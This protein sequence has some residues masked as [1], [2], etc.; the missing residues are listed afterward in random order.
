MWQFVGLLG[1]LGGRFGAIMYK[2]LPPLEEFKK[3]FEYNPDTGDFIW[4]IGP[5]KGKVAGGKLK[6]GIYL[7]HKSLGRFMAHR[8][9]WLWNY[10]EDPGELQIDHKDLDQFNNKKNNLRKAT[11]Q[12][13]G[14]NTGLRKDNTSGVKGVTIH[15]NK[16]KAR[17]RLNGKELYLGLF[18]TIE[19]AKEA[20]SDCR[21][22]HQGEF[23]RDS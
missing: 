15:G 10:G 3:V 11:N 22:I 19:E 14:F 9:A 21:K 17:I 12:Q 23:A 13:N 16:F 8:V 2:P 18:D 1:G 4:L 5:R 7:S 6:N 20:L